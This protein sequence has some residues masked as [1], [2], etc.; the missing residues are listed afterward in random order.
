MTENALFW[1]TGMQFHLNMIFERMQMECVL[2]GDIISGI[3]RVKLSMNVHLS[4]T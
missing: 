3:Q 4:A 1:E 2:S